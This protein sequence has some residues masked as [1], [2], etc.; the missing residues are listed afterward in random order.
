MLR[1]PI[2]LDNCATTACDARVVDTLLPYFTQYFGNPSSRNHSF[3]WK[4]AIAVE[5]AQQQVAGLINATADE[6][7]FTSGATESCNL[8]LRGICSM[9]AGKGDHIIT[10]KVEH[11]AVLDTCKTLE[12]KGAHVTYLDV[13]ADGQIDL[14]VLKA[15]LRAN[16]ILIAVQWANNETGVLMPVEAIGAIAH[17][18]NI[19]FFCDATQAVGK[20]PVDVK[21]AKPALMAFSSHK[22]YGP[23]GVGALYISRKDPRVKITSQITGGGQQKNIRSGTLNVPGIVGFGKACALAG[24][25][26]DADGHR[27]LNLRNKLEQA[28]LSLPETFVNGHSS[29]RLPQVTNLSFGYL[30]SN[31]ILSILNKNIAVSSG[32]ACTSGSLDPSYVLKAMQQTDDRAK[33]AIRFSL[34]RFTT[35]EEIDYTLQFV[36]T[37]ITNLRENSPAWQLRH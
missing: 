31:E 25:E 36:R 15:S 9:Y 13:N 33:A 7:Y 8:A 27:L 28:L 22:L 2:Y 3:G 24:E 26:M 17:E 30:N 32:S 16:T 34:G 1:F 29:Q 6:V 37:A 23:K 20:I 4:A 11:K 21:K 14:N 35:A 19:L 10:T 5:A 12:K 18:K